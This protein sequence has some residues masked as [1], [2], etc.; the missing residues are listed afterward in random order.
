MKDDGPASLGWV[1]EIWYFL[2]DLRFVWSVVCILSMSVFRVSVFPTQRGQSS[3]RSGQIR[4]AKAQSSQCSTA[5]LVEVLPCA[6]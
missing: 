1:G 5:A 2:L 3:S 6:V 4:S